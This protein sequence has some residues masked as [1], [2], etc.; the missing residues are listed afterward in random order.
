MLVSGSLLAYGSSAQAAHFT[1]CKKR[2]PLRKL[3]EVI[4]TRRCVIL[5]HERDG[6]NLFMGVWESVLVFRFRMGRS[7]KLPFSRHGF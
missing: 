2:L 5:F 6:V 3:S 4:H 1:G 7:E